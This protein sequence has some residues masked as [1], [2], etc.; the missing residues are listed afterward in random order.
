MNYS[1]RAEAQILLNHVNV[2]IAEYTTAGTRLELYT[3]LESLGDRILYFD[4]DSIVYIERPGDPSPPTENF[5]G[6]MTD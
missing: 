1:T 3:Y 2:V 5:L 4:T 6:D